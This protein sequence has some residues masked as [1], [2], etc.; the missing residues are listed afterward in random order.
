MRTWILAVLS[1]TLLVF[2]TAC[3]KDQ[4]APTEANETLALQYHQIIKDAEAASG[5][6]Y[7]ITAVDI[8][9]A[10]HTYPA[11][12]KGQAVSCFTQCDLQALLDCYPST[13]V[14][15][16]VWDFNNDGIVNGA[17]LL[18]LLGRFCQPTVTAAT[19]LSGNELDVTD[20]MT[21]FIRNA[22][23]IDGDLWINCC[24]VSI[25]ESVEWYFDGALVSISPFGLQLEYPGATIYDVGID[26]NKGKHLIT[27]KVVIN[28]TEYYAHHCV[29]IK[30]GNQIPLCTSNYCE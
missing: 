29:K 19:D 13:A 27:L 23:L 17:D 22:T 24:D 28:C 7:G 11:T 21:G 3:E 2:T 10:L 16:L 9:E 6:T 5:Q 20:Q 30:M 18:Y 15:C 25:F 1:C 26:C 14:E 12:K 4:A 8:E